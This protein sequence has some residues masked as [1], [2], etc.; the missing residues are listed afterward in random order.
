[1]SNVRVVIGR[2]GPI[3]KTGQIDRN[4]R[5]GIVRVRMGVRQVIGVRMV[6]GDRGGRGKVGGENVFEK[7]AVNQRNANAGLRH[8]LVS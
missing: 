6:R 4:V 1:M 3:G 5:M 8:I 2:K 7:C